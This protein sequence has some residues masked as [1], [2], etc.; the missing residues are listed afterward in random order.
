MSYRARVRMGAQVVDVTIDADGTIGPS[1]FDLFLA[2]AVAAR[3]TVDLTVTGPT[4]RVDPSDRYAVIAWLAD[5]FDV[6]ADVWP[7]GWDDPRT[8]LPDG[9]VG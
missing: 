2:E 1:P 4:V 9:A 6:I 5:T 8:V 7:D 3:T